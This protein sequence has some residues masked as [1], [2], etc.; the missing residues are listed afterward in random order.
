MEGYVYF[1]E[2]SPAELG[3]WTAAL[4]EPR[5]YWVAD[6][7]QLTMG[8]DLPQNW[9]DRGAIFGPKGELRFWR[10]EKDFQALLLADAPVP[11]LTPLPGEW[12]VKEE[13]FFLQDLREQRLCPN[14]AT[15]PDGRTKGKVQAKVYHRDGVAAIV[16]LRVLAHQ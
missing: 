8:Q 5:W 15:Y 3:T 11:D 9:K 14:F 10:S 2:G 6:G 13:V 1:L 7:A 12:T 4:G 16:S